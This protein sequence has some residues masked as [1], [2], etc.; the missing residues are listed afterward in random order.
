MKNSQMFLKR[1]K[2]F[3]F[4]RQQ[5]DSGGHQRSIQSGASCKPYFCKSFVSVRFARARHELQKQQQQKNTAKVRF[6]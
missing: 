3:F 6:T 1:S 5:H 4:C 2:V